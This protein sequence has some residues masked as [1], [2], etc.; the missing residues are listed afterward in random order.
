MLKLYH[1]PDARSLR[2]LWLFEELTLPYELETMPFPP[3]VAAPHYLEVNPI[4]TVPYLV[5][6]ETTLNE[7]PAILEY[8]AIKHG[9]G[10]CAVKPE[11]AVYGAWLNWLQFGECALTVPLALY[12]RFAVFAPE[13]Q[14]QPRIG[15]DF[16]D[17]FSQ[18]VPLVEQA[19]V[20]QDYLC[21]NRFTVADISVGYALFLCS[22]IG[23]AKLLSEPLTAYLARLT[24]RPAFITARARQKLKG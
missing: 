12:L 23:L 18:R 3:R 21:A 20:G 14:R 19:L 13:E 1:C 10:R 11:E 4:G 7:S 16:C 6:G 2:C 15:A 17:L 9:S 5:D 22:R 8:V 24:S